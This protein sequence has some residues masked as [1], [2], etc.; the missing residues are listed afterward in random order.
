MEKTYGSDHFNGEIGIGADGPPVGWVAYECGLHECGG[1]D[2]EEDC[3][4]KRPVK[5]FMIAKPGV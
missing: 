4:S 2:S 3:N 1:D 5:S